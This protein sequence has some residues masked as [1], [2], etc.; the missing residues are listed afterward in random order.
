MEVTFH[1]ACKMPSLLEI[2]FSTQQLCFVVEYK[3]LFVA[4]ESQP[5]DKDFVSHG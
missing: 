5:H 1:V 4:T 3:E 2:Y